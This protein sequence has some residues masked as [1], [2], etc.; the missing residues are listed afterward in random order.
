M[1]P[2]QSSS[3]T[4]KK[5]LV[6]EDEKPLADALEMKLK[7]EGFAVARATN[8]Q[9]GLEAVL[10]FSPDVILLDLMMPV[11]DGK[12]ML[13]KLRDLPQFK[14]LPIIVLTNAGTVDNIRETQTFFNAAEFFIKSNVSLEAIVAKIKEIV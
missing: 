11:M 3:P 13:R 1:S 6:V 10:S 5:V 7:H 14:T 2:D 8:G 9:E 12:T 4:L